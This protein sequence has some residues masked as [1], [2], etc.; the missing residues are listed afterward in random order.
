MLLIYINIDLESF[1][2]GRASPIT[3]VS[4][5]ATPEQQKLHYSHHS[6][7]TESRA[8][9]AIKLQSIGT[10]MGTHFNRLT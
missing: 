7:T 4:L 2:L 3:M 9:E 1:L 8:R 10:H 6:Q 5:F